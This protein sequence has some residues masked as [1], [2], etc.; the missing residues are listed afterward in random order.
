MTFVFGASI[1]EIATRLWL[2]EGAVRNH[3]STAMQ[4]LSAQKR[5]EAA[6]LAEQKGWL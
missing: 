6:R 5:M 2:S 3:L 4:K 1:A